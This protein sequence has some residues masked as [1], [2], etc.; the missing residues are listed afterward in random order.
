MRREGSEDLPK[1][2][3][4]GKNAPPNINVLELATYRY[5]DSLIGNTESRYKAIDDI[6]CKNIPRIKNIKTGDPIVKTDNFFEEIPKAIKNLDESY[7][8]IQGP[9]GT[10]KTTQASNAIIQLLKDKKRVGIVANS[11][12]VINNLV[13]KVEDQAVKEKF[14]FHGI[15]KA[16]LGNEESH[17]KGEMVESFY[18]DNAI[19]QQVKSKGYSLFAGTKYHFGHSFYDQ[20]LDYI[21]VDEAGQLTTADIIVI[22]TAAKNIVLIGD[23]MQLPQPSSADHPGESGK[24]VLEYLL[25][26]NDT[27][28]EDR[29]I[30]LNKSYRMHPNVNDFISNNF[31]EERLNCDERTS[32]REIKLSSKT[33]LNLK[34]INYIDANHS[35]YSQRNEIEGEIVKKL[36][37]NLL[38]STFKD[39]HG[40]ERKIKIDDILT[41]SP[42]NI[43]VNYL[44]SI[45]PED[46]R[47]GTIDKF[48]GQEAPVTLISMATSDADSIPRGLDFL[49]NRNR[50]NVAI[51]RSQLMSIIIFSPDLLMANAKKVD[52]IFLIE[53]FF[54]LM[55]YKINF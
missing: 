47:V 5:F 14:H 42:Y 48:Q 9:P 8:F 2:L 33:S 31:Y 21:F 26:N 11:H 34:G 7:V 22:G 46:S 12:R 49:F 19:V 51:S 28:K 18:K 3:S 20:E 52:E 15:K 40:K 1:I 16:S 53:N 27:V 38:G 10:G 4:I 23:Q 32:K 55:E 44:K 37:K 29:G 54:K 17:Y 45:L 30:F 41:I 25:E 36:Y 35:D 39:E 6:L 13:K 50:L 43:Q 24:S